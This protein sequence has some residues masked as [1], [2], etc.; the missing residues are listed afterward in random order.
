MNRWTQSALLLAAISLPAGLLAYRLARGRV[1][2]ETPHLAPILVDATDEVR[3][4]DARSAAKKVIVQELMA[5]R[6]SLLR[7]AASFRD[8]NA[9][10]PPQPYSIRDEFPLA[11][12]EEEAYCLSVI[13]WVGAGRPPDRARELARRLHEELDARLREG[14][15]RLPTPL[16][17]SPPPP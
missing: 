15:L 4:L 13:A 5:G 11:S 8:L 1:G 7:T 2:L 17:E 3:A 6:L 14:E 10:G 12:S 16:E 9:Q